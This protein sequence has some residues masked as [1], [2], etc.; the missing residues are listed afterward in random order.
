MNKILVFGF[1]LV[2]LLLIGGC[3][4]EE[5]AG[6]EAADELLLTPEEVELLG[7]T[8]LVPVDGSGALAGQ[9]TKVGKCFVYPTS[10]Q[11]TVSATGV[12]SA[13]V[14]GVLRTWP[15]SCYGVLGSQEH[16]CTGMGE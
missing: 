1:L 4:S 11:C 2:S 10:T 12:V 9:A 16:S 15:H 8:E 6:G 14:N 5:S 3:A 7:D 13:K